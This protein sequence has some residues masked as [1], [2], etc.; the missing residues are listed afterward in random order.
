VAKNLALMGLGYMFIADMD[1]VS[2]SNLSRAVYF[3][4]HDA[5]EES[6]KAE[7][8]AKRARAMNVSE[9]AFTRP[10]PGDIVWQLGA[11]IFRRVDVVLGC[12]DN[13]EARL[14]ANAQCLL[15]G[16]PYIDGAIS[17]LA[18]NV[19]AV[20]APHTACWSC[21]TNQT[22]RALAAN[23]YHSCTQVMLRA[24]AEGR[25][26]TVQVASSIIAGFQSQEAVK[27]IQGRPWAAGSIIRYSANGPRPDL[28]VIALPR[29]P[30]CWCNEAQTI[31]QVI[32]LPLSANTHTLQDLINELANHGYRDIH[33]ML[34]ARFIIARAC[35]RCQQSEPIMQPIFT[36][37]TSVLS[38]RFCAAGAN[39]TELQAV[40]TTRPAEFDPLENGTAIRER[41]LVL[42]LSSLGFPPLALLWF[43]AGEG[44]ESFDYTAELSADAN[45][46]MGDEVYASVRS[47]SERINDG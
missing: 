37:D 38:C 6:Y 32:E 2:W 17:G 39:E 14:F 35:L 30:E 43:C 40:E 18:G 41:M 4:R 44:S 20:H 13:V 27:V 29:N 16:T 28:D 45:E 19:T 7:L 5:E 9:H 25:L 22:I 47:R 11:G 33:V 3:Q 8:V 1:K 46:V 21:T 12:L 31:E 34:P 24:Q 26:P 15:T 42:P 36:L 10:F 23:R